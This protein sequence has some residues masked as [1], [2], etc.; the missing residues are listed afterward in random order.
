[1]MQESRGYFLE[2]FAQEKV[3]MNLI[4]SLYVALTASFVS[5]VLGIITAYCYIVVR[6]NRIKKI[7]LSMLQLALM[8]PYVF[9]ISLGML[10]L[11][12]TGLLS[13]FLYQVGILHDFTVFPALIF[14]Q[15]G[16]GILWVYVFKGTPFVAVF[17]MNGMR[18][19]SPSYAQVAKTLGAGNF[20][21]LRKIYLPLCAK[22][23]VWA[24]VVLFAYQLGSFEVPYLLSPISPLPLSAQLYSLY[25]QTEGDGVPKAMAMSLI[26]LVSGGLV[27]GL[28]ALG[29]YKLVRG[30]GG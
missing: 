9:A 4:F 11:A 26:I 23:I 16:I 8:L 18:Q 12:K 22:T 29:L 2:L 6:H 14:D 25:H 7:T 17:V 24:T 30:Q 19:V 10:F 15:L 1:M 27:G 3:I 28:Y 20:M 13:R 21:M 5:M